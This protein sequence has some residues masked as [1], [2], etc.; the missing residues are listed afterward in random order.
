MKGVT[1]GIEQGA[2]HLGI[3]TYVANIT[4]IR[5][6]FDAEQLCVAD[7]CTYTFEFTDVHKHAHGAR[8]RTHTHCE[9]T[10]THTHSSLSHHGEGFAA[11][12]RDAAAY[13]V[14]LAVAWG[15]S[16][17][18]DVSVQLKLVV[19]GFHGHVVPKSMA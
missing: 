14:C 12:G 9:L 15:I 5:H 13:L 3:C 19:T 2:G 1:E 4:P 11:R 17:A 16:P 8:A 7:A 18:G 10:H 6:F